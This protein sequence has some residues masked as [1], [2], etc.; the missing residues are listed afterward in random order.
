MDK[1]IINSAT[2]T[3]IAD[4]IRMRGGTADALYP[5]DMADA[6]LAIA[7]D[8]PAGIEFGEFTPEEDASTVKVEHHLG[9]IPYAVFIWK[10]EMPLIVSSLRAGV[11]VNGVVEYSEEA[12]R[13]VSTY[14]LARTI[15]D[16]AKYYIT[17]AASQGEG[18]DGYGD[19]ATHFFT[20]E[21][22]GMRYLAGETYKW[23][24]VVL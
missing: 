12:G 14:G 11:T 1:V 22:T 13:D 15:K 2:L 16:S 3:S 18:E 17:S 7:S 24:A 4:A 10:S 21:S 8:L 6:V 19:T 5:S 23:M 20:P 9:A